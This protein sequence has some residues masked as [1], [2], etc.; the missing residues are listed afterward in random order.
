MRF[1]KGKCN[2]LHLGHDSPHY[3]YRLVEHSP[4]KK[5]LGI[6]VDGKLNMSQQCTLTSQKDNLILSYIKNIKASR[7]RKVILPLCSV[8]VRP[9]LE[10]CV[11]TWSPQYR[12]YFT[13]M[14]VRHQNV[15]PRELVDA[16]SLETA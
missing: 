5:D 2:V 9:H 8:L 16:P 6:L 7:L 14:V 15:L 1:N 13:I 4:A 12:T 3:Q 11:Q 10:Y